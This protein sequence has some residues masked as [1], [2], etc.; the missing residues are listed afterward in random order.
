M[1][2]KTLRKE[3]EERQRLTKSYINHDPKGAEEP[4]SLMAVNLPNEGNRVHD[5]DMI[6][7]EGLYN[8]M[9][10]YLE[11]RRSKAK[12]R[13]L[14]SNRALKRGKHYTCTAAVLN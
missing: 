8:D 10:P 5:S 9:G 14:Y 11:V 3:R 12:G 6:Q 7:F 1:S 2:F 4:A 13:G